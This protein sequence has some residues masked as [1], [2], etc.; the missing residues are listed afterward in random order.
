MAQSSFHIPIPDTAPSPQ[1]GMMICPNLPSAKFETLSSS[2]MSRAPPNLDP[3]DLFVDF[4]YFSSKT[5]VGSILLFLGL[6]GE[7]LGRVHQ[8]S[9]TVDIRLITFLLHIRASA[10]KWSP[11]NMLVEEA[12]SPCLQS[13]S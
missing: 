4:I 6:D 5:I 8:T 11:S 3:Q 1:N 10:D 9:Q 12:I 13:H 2:A 7:S